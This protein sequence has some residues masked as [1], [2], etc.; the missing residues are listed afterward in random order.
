MPP[1]KF[2]ISGN[3]NK[4]N[5]VLNSLQSRIMLNNKNSIKNI[6]LKLPSNVSK[7][8]NNNSPYLDSI[9]NSDP[10]KITDGFYKL[11]RISEDGSKGDIQFI[12]V[13]NNG[14]EFVFEEAKDFPFVFNTEIKR[15]ELLLGTTVFSWLDFL[16]YNKDNKTGKGRAIDQRTGPDPFDFIFEKVENLELFNLPIPEPIMSKNFNIEDGTYEIARNTIDLGTKVNFKVIERFIFE[17][18]KLKY[19]D[20]RLSEDSFND[21]TKQFFNEQPNIY[22]ANF[23]Y[24][25]KYLVKESNIRRLRILEVREENNKLIIKNSF[26]N[27]DFELIF[28]LK[29]KKLTKLL[30]LNLLKDAYTNAQRVAGYTVEKF[31]N[32]NASLRPT[33]ENFIYSPTTKQPFKSKLDD[34]SYEISY[35]NNDDKIRFKVLDNGNTLNINNS[36]LIYSETDN[37]YNGT[38]QDDIFIKILNYNINFDNMILYT[39]KPTIKDGVQINILEYTNATKIENTTIEVEILKEPKTQEKYDII[40]GTYTVTSTSLSFGRTL[41]QMITTIIKDKKIKH[42]SV[43]YTQETIDKYGYILGPLNPIIYY[44]NFEYVLPK[45]LA[46]DNNETTQL[47]KVYI[48]NNTFVRETLSN[49]GRFKISLQIENKKLVK[50]LPVVLL[51][52]SSDPGLRA[53][54]FTVDEFKDSSV[55]DPILYSS[56]TEEPSNVGGVVYEYK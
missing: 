31:N 5:L 21:T 17:N 3:K 50:A 45:Y 37:Q 48:E 39:R 41:V 43:L 25:V 14:D 49:L 38:I 12:T 55:Y 26:I 2:E 51:E 4:T 16:T 35:I 32:E 13:R 44:S 6:E 53:L 9:E 36:D 42:I 10:L 30:E 27:G 22:F 29:N 56:S 15:Y 18:G 28:E 54:G 33:F 24:I 20:S 1:M 19:Y 40:D 8:E 11:T 52:D 47:E 7:E 23:E 34:G 46:K